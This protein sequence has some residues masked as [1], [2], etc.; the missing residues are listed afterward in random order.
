[1]D[2]NCAYEE[3]LNGKPIRRKNWLGGVFFRMIEI[4][5]PPGIMVVDNYKTPV[6]FDVEDVRASDWEVVGIC[7]YCGRR[8]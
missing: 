5:E 3:L 1:M 4:D 2:F 7:E 8:G 6:R